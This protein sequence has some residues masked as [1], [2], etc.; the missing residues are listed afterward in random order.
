MVR[1]KIREVSRGL[2]M[3]SVECFF[4]EFGFILKV[5]G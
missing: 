5:E 4:K 1:I 3:K 2:I